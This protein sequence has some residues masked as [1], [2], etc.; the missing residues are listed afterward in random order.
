MLIYLFFCLFIQ[1]L[2][3][4]MTGI[5]IITELLFDCRQHLRDETLSTEFVRD[6]V[7]SL[8]QCVCDI[9]VTNSFM[10]MTINRCIDYTKASKGLKLVPKFETTELLETLLLPL[11]CMKNIQNKVHIEL[12]S[13][14]ASICSHVITD[15]QWLQENVLC[16][17]SNAVKYSASGKISVAV[18]LALDTSSTGGNSSPSSPASSPQRQAAARKTSSLALLPRSTSSSHINF[19]RVCPLSLSSASAEDLGIKPD[20]YVLRVEVEDEGIGMTEQA[21]S[22][23][24]SPFKQTQRLAG[25]TGLGLFSLAKRIEALRGQCGVCRRRDGKQGSLFWFTI[26][27]RPDE[28]ERRKKKDADGGL[29][30][31]VSVDSIGDV[32]NLNCTIDE[33]AIMHSPYPP[34]TISAADMMTQPMVSHS[35]EAQLIPVAIQTNSSM[36]SQS[37]NQASAPFRILLVDDSPSVLKMMSMMLRR[38]GHVVTIA[39][40]GAIALDLLTSRLS[41]RSTEQSASA[42]STIFDIV[43]MDLQMPVMDGIEAVKRLRQFEAQRLAIANTTGYVDQTS[44]NTV[45]DDHAVRMSSQSRQLVIGLSANCED[46]VLQE[47][48]SVGFD[49]FLPKPFSLNSFLELVNELHV[50]QTALLEI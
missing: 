23:L 49:A 14:P 1:P 47:T 41:S 43:L 7:G 18:S 25:G 30:R 32:S 29:S 17:L 13:L 36:H 28:E 48:A 27:Y 24:F 40:N 35:A 33:E 11:S 12:L 46:D 16:L 22:E 31:V 21:M 10:L 3:S 9:R 4:F 8:H 19:R 6:M 5:D 26:P 37:S 20:K 38:Q 39:E 42:V 34:A 44:R 15:K 2:S 50:V 45:H